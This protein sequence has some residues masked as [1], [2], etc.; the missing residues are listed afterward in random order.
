M[1][2]DEQKQAA[3][4][5]AAAWVESGMVVGLGTGSTAVHAIRA[6]RR[7]A[8]TKVSC[9]TSSGSRR[10]LPVRRRHSRRG[11]PLTS[12]RRASGGRS[13]H[14]RCRRGR[15][16]ARSD[17]GRW[18]RVV[19]REDG[20]A[21]EC[22]RGASSSTRRSRRRELGTQ[23]ALPVEV[24]QFGWRPE[25]EYLDDLGADGHGPARRRRRRVRDRRGQLDPRLRVRP[26]RRHRTA[27]G[28]TR[29]PRRDRGARTVP[30]ARDRPAR[31]RPDR[32][33]APDRAP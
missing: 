32:R 19:A 7:P 14:R 13:H 5:L 26:D 4:E 21:G 24:A 12:A 17:Q 25:A 6:H 30:R 31:R 3:G 2:R 9:T 33:R 29:S 16:R 10:R 18:R 20:G 11:I 27:R 22:P 28:P 15:P 1:S 8:R 23:F